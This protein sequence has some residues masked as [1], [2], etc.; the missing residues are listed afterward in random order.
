MEKLDL[1]ADQNANRT[2]KTPKTALNRL[3]N[4]LKVPVDTGFS[5]MI[6]FANVS[7]PEKVNL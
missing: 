3:N 6:S 5:A 7:N 1:D 4:T 2:G